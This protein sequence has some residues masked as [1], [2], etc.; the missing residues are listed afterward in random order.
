MKNIYSKDNPYYHGVMFHHIH[1]G[2]KYQKS[3]GSISIKQFERTLKYI[4]IENILTPD[5]FLKKYNL[6]KLKKNEVCLTFDDGLKCHKDIV[7]K[8]LNKYDLKGIFFIYTS[9]FDKNPNL[10]ECYR[11]FRLTYFKNI[12][13]FY[14]LF[15]LKAE[16]VISQKK[17]KSFLNKNKQ[18]IIS[19]KKLYSFYTLNDL[20][21]RLLRD[22]L[23]N[24]N[25]YQSLMMQLFKEKNFDYRKYIKKSTLSKK[26]I[27]YLSKKGH[28][29]GLHSHSH[30]TSLENKNINFQGKDFKKNYSILKNITK[31]KPVFASYPLG[32][33][34]LNSINTLKKLNIKLAFR[35]N[36]KKDNLI[37]TKKINGSRLEIARE[38][39]AN[40]KIN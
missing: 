28:S 27:Q 11:F 12:N 13:S 32:K 20:K 40:I 38:D 26:D 24:L 5:D 36:V 9:I 14:K 29:I 21:F 30:T 34:N 4:G 8:V 23:L 19:L 18:K 17:I 33:Y 37:I 16:N 31:V 7:A 3:Q 22:G 1:D 6:K 2:K 39:S 10:F 35:A 15:F 25:Q